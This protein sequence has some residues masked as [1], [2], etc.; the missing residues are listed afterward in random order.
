[1]AKACHKH[2]ARQKILWTIAVIN[3]Y[4]FV[5]WALQHSCFPMSAVRNTRLR[6]NLSLKLLCVAF[7]GDEIDYCIGYTYVCAVIDSYAGN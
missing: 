1:M 2:V 4:F 3:H 6:T 7:G 5:K